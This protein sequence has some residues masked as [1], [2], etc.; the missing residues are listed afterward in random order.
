MDRRDSEPIAAVERAAAHR[1]ARHRA[2]PRTAHY[3][4]AAL[5]EQ[6][7][8]VA[9]S[10]FAAARGA[11]GDGWL[12]VG[13]VLD[14]VAGADFRVWLHP[15]TGRVTT[16]RLGPPRPDVPSPRRP[17]APVFDGERL[18]WVEPGEGGDR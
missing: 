4:A 13:T 6:V 17:G 7:V 10:P 3:T 2:D 12:P 15:A 9:A 1:R 8:G 5:E 14:G 16:E 11:T 18:R